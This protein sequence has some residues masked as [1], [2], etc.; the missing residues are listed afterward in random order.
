MAVLFALL[1]ALPL[2]GDFFKD[3]GWY[4]GPIAW[5]ACSIVSARV[6]PL[7]AGVVLFAA[8]AGGI[9][10]L[11]VSLVAGHTPGLAV[12]LLVFAA[13]NAGYDDELDTR[14]GGSAE[15]PTADTSPA[16]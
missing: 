10:G 15:R 2:P 1:V 11:L 6:L 14:P 16:P 3:N 12:A 7:P 9:C 4:V 5:I 8:L 13:S